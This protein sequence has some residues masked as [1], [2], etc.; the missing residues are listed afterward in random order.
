[1]RMYFIWALFVSVNVLWASPVRVDSVKTYT[2]NVQKVQGTIERLHKFPSKYITPRHVDVW[3]P[4]NY[5]PKKR[6][7]VLYAH[8]GQMLFNADKLGMVKNLVWTNTS[9]F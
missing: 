6:Y 8:D 5:D 3:M 9:Q 7:A 2:L 4:E 1:M